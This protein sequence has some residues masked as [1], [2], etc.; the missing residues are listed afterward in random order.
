MKCHLQHAF[1]EHDPRFMFVVTS[2]VSRVRPSR[3]HTFEREVEASRGAPKRMGAC[4]Y[5]WH[6]AVPIYWSLPHVHCC[7]GVNIPLR[8]HL[9]AVAVEAE[10]QNVSTAYMY[11]RLARDLQ[12]S[13]TTCDKYVH[14]GNTL[15]KDLE[16]DRSVHFIGRVRVRNSCIPSRKDLSICLIMSDLLGPPCRGLR[17]NLPI[18][19]MTQPEISRTST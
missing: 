4:M 2:G 10:S 11:L 8:R 9:Q 6:G 14:V 3:G 7:D 15:T 5:V 17:A 18:D 19:G 13:Y 16:H 12:S 1:T